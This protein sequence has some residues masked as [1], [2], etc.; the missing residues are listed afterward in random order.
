MLDF[1]LMIEAKDTDDGPFIRPP[2]DS[3]VRAWAPHG[4]PAY[5]E[6]A[7]AL[8]SGRLEFPG[9]SQGNC[10]VRYRD[11]EPSQIGYGG[12]TSDERESR[13]ALRRGLPR[14]S[15]ATSPYRTTRDSRDSRRLSHFPRSTQLLGQPGS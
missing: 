14:S 9:R 12:V 15:W 11:G 4:R 8:D 6:W 13:T 5:E 10:T 2:A 1:P 3:E 7:A